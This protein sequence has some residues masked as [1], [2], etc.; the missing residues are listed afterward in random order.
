MSEQTCYYS[1]I[2]FCPDPSRLEGVNVGVGLYSPSEKRVLVKITRTNLRIKRFFG[3]QNW[4]L[5]NRAKTSVE[6]QLKSQQ[7]SDVEDFKSYISKRA[8]SIQ[9]SSPRSVRIADSQRSLQELF[10]RL[11]GPEAPERRTRIN[12]LLT[13]RFREA[14]VASMVERP[15]PIEIPGIDTHIQVPY[16]YQNG[17]FN[18]IAPVQFDSS[19]DIMAKTGKS[20]IEGKLL[21]ERPH[22]T[23]GQ[24]CLV[25]VANFDEQIK[26]S[27]REFISRTLSDHS[28]KLYSFDNLGPLVDDIRHSAAAHKVP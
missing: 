26:S 19:P 9:L 28:V 3:N 15:L 14:G 1:L 24:M 20:A 17:C 18:L 2:Q 7:F 27:T 25:V 23:L 16:A 5:I 11:V 10:E 12:G 6:N 21:N 4:P 8:N 13:K 22:P